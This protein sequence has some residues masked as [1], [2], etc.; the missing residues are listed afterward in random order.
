M[1]LSELQESLPAYAGDLR[2]NLTRVLRETPLTDVQAWGAALA[3]AI[4]SRSATVV[5]VLA[6]EASA[7]LAP[8]VVAQAKAAAS[9]MAMNN[10]Y[11]RAQ[12]MIGATHPVGLRMRVITSPVLA[13]AGVTRADFE[14]WCLAVSA[15][16]GCEVCLKNHDQG[17]RRAGLPGT[18]VPE[19]LR[20]AAVVH[21]TAVTVDASEALG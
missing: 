4:A 15:I 2:E 3:C 17:V 14:L 20:I 1:N 7:R 19:A 18:A 21:A 11:Y 5:R 6:A 8:P 12:H 13:A 9:I 10:V 16:A